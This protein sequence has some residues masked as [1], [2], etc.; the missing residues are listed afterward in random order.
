M[1]ENAENGLYVT[2][3]R[4]EN[5]T[6]K[7]LWESKSEVEQLCRKARKAMLELGIPVHL[8][9]ETGTGKSLIARLIHQNL[10]GH[11]GTP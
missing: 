5:G 2:D 7:L 6:R 4:T 1:S 10:N 3:I 8:F 11:S 9:G